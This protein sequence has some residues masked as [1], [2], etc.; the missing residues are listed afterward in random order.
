MAT[1][2]N[3]GR[4]MARGRS[5]P[6]LTLAAALGCGAVLVL[7]LGPAAPLVPAARAAGAG[8]TA[9]A[10]PA[11]AGTG[12]VSGHA[13][14]L[15]ILDQIRLRASEDHPYLGERTARDLRAELAA[16]PAEAPDGSLTHVT[17]WRL[18]YQLGWHELFLGNTRRTIELFSDAHAMLPRVRDMLSPELPVLLTFD[19]GVAYMRLAED[20]NCAHAGNAESCL[21]PIRGGGV[22]TDQEGARRAIDY[23]LEVLRN[24]KPESDIHLANR[25]LLNIAYMTVGDH[26][27]GVPEPYVIP[28]AAFERGEAFPRFGNIAARLGLDGLSLAGGAVADDFD[29][30]GYLDLM[31]S[32]WDPSGQL[33]LFLNQA[34]GTFADRTREAGLLGLYGGLNMVHADYDN[35]GDPDVLVLRGAWLYEDG[36][37]P[38]S[39]LRNEGDGHFVDVTFEAGLGEAHY[40]TQ[41][42][43]WADYD[44][45]GDLD[46]Y[47]GNESSYG[48]AIPFTRRDTIGPRTSA[49]NFPCQLFRNDGDGTFTDV[50]AEAGVTNDRYAKAVVWGDYDGDVRPDLYVSNYQGQ[51]RLYH[52]DGNGRFT[53]V[54]RTLGVTG[55]EASFPAWFWDFDNDGALDLFV[56][57]YSASNRDLAAIALGLPTQGEAPRLY[58]GDGRGGLRDAADPL[59]LTQPSAPMGSNFGDL[60]NDGYLDFYLG[61]GY[62]DYE[63]LMPNRMY[64]NKAGRGF[65]EVTTSGGFGHLQKGH[66]VVFADFDNDGDQDVFEQMGGA[67]LGDKARDVF[68]ENP[69]LGNH[70]IAITLV[71]VRANRSAIGATIRVDVREDGERRTIYKHVNGGGTFGANPLRQTV[72]LGK[73]SGIERLEVVWPGG[74]VQQ[75]TDVPLDRFL[76]LVEGQER[77]ETLSLR[78][79]DLTARGDGQHGMPGAGPG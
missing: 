4:R 53:D 6:W 13:R 77:V 61:T 59:H 32:S 57:A 24:T 44:D 33:R 8:Q 21:L 27:D 49:V 48:Q 11:Q 14:M 42:A 37:H 58:R 54:A 63:H 5:V 75:F 68:Y 60:D 67:F 50:A 70:W 40:P 2:G 47:V 19:L 71:G 73:A 69:G 25:W 52:N 45:D 72:G 16:L 10:P 12:S 29:G 30:D 7:P 28:V 76:R 3:D 9:D 20:E 43:A 62:P 79:L 15:A 78:R 17:R 23:F 34:D 56:S 55:P 18:S 38:N 46:L 64:H 74:R 1:R 22:H 41:T 35:D 31:T 39:L 65:V 26:P 66:G 36:R 51:N